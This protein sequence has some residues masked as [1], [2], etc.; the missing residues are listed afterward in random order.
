MIASPVATLTGTSG[1]IPGNQVTLL[2]NGEAFFPA[3]EQAFDRAR[4]EI[5]LVTYIYRDDSTGQR[6][7][8]ALK[9]AVLRGVG[10]QVVVDGYGSS[11]LSDA[12][13]DQMR[14]DGIEL[15]IFRPGISPWTLRRKRLR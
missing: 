4:F 3:I 1:F 6:I 14:Q 11:D 2:Q 7:A 9:R 8:A 12:L 10:V 13:R 5:Y 15:R